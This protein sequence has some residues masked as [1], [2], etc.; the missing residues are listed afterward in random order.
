MYG[1][2][3]VLDVR[4]QAG[5]LPMSR[6][7][8]QGYDRYKPNARFGHCID[9]SNGGSG[10]K[11]LTPDSEVDAV[12][13]LVAVGV[14]LDQGSRAGDAESALPSEEVVPTANLGTPNLPI[15]AVP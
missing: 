15:C 2:I 10:A 1:I 5:R 7:T 13:A 4:W 8:S 12:D 3:V 14:A 6:P 11:I 9:R